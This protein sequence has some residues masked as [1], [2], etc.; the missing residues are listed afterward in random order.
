M[1]SFR[2]VDRVVRIYTALPPVS[3]REREHLAANM[4][5]AMRDYHVNSFHWPWCMGLRLMAGRPPWL[6]FPVPKHWRNYHGPHAIPIA[7]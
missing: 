1:P 3:D 2:E 5:V 6:P 7:A 4:Q